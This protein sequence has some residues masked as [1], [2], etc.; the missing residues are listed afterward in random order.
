MRIQK[1]NI[2]EE[3]K[4]RKKE[5]R[6]RKEEIGRRGR[7]LG[8]SGERKGDKQYAGRG[9]ACT[10]LSGGARDRA[11]RMHTLNNDKFK[12][13]IFMRREKRG[14]KEKGG[15]KRGDWKEERIKIIGRKED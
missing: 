8:L 11:C 7:G 5:K 1:E 6:R 2:F 4:M 15:E 10:M 14:K 3:R 12:R 13:K 9:R